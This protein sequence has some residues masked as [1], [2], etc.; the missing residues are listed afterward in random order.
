M[1]G[2]DAIVIGGGIVG[3]SVLFSLTRVGLPRVLLC[4]QGRPPG[5]GATPSSGGLLRQHHTAPCDTALAVLGVRRFQAWPDEVGGSCGYRQTG[6]AIV[7]GPEHADQLAKNVQR[8]NEAGG[9]SSV[10]AGEDLVELHPDLCVPGDV[11]VGYE[12]DGGYVDPSLATTSILAAAVDAGAVVSEGVLVTGVR[13]ASG[14]V[15]GLDTTLGRLDTEVVVLCGAASTPAA[16]AGTGVDLPLEPRRIGI[17]RAATGLKA[18]RLPACIDDIL[19]TYFRPV[20]D[21]SLVFGV[22]LAAADTPDGSI[23]VAQHE[24]SAAASRLAPRVPALRGAA[25]AGARIGVDAYTPDKRPAIGWTSCEGLY[26]CTGFS[27]GGVK[28]APAVA[29]LVAHEIAEGIRSPLL[30]PYDPGRFGAGR[31]IESDFSYAHM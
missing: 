31:L 12:P 23:P 4:E 15:V 24:A 11:A 18:G 2:Y 19:G 10:I 17:A 1:T 28:V 6:F 8:V 21:G 29:R 14:R 25:L 3:A 20:D 16:I 26:A 27:G 7:V 13:T 22:R 30:E 5:R 9:R